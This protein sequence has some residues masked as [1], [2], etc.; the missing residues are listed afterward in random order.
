MKKILKETLA[1]L[2]IFIFKVTNSKDE[3]ILSVYFHN[4]SKAM[5][6]KIIKW[7]ITNGYKFISTK[8]L[9]LIINQKRI[10]HKL[11]CITFDDGWKQNLDLLKIIEKYK[12]PITI[13]ISTQAMIEGN[14]WFE[15][16]RIKNQHIH[17][18]IKKVKDFKKLPANILSEKILIL[19]KH[20][21]LERSCITLE[22]LR[23]IN[24]NELI[25]IGSHTVTH[26]ILK[27]C[28]YDIQK[29]ELN[30]S[31][32]MLTK[33]L[34]R[35]VEYFAYPN[36]DFNAE[37]ISIVKQCGYKLCFTT[38]PAKIQEEKTHPYLI[39]RY[40][41]D[42]RGGYLENISKILGIWQK[43]IFRH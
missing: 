3:G 34:G 5:F 12:I 19:K 43:F 35:D 10:T 6:L 15:Y 18:K 17:T 22:E 39:P 29:Y 25:T 42:D 14:Y 26:P 36:G 40:S 21:L 23:K 33:W 2:L 28:S 9:E 32:S 41:I 27:E 13:F 24:E 31:K 37:T 11:V 8:Q 7:L 30:N 38:I 20:F 1:L 16:A 4:P